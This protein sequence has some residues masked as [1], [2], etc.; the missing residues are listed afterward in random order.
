MS[1]PVLIIGA[2]VAGMTAAV[3]LADSG[4][5]TILVERKYTVG[6]N[7]LDLYK[8]FPTD[9]CFYCFEGNRSRPGIR[10]CFYR[11]ALTDQPNIELKIGSQIEE[12]SGEPGKFSVNI[13]IG[14]QYVSPKKCIMCGLCLEYSEA[15]TLISPQCQPQAMT[16]DPSKMDDGAKKSQ[17]ECPTKAIDLDAKATTETVLVSDIVIATGYHE[18]QPVNV[19]E[20][21][22]GKHPNIITQLELAKILDPNGKTEGKVVRPSDGSPAKRIMMVQCVGSRDEN[23]YPY[24]SKICCVFALKHANILALERE[25]VNCSVVYMDIRTY[26]RH[27]RYYREAREA[28]VEFIRGRITRVDPK[29]D[30]LEVIVYDSLLDKYLKF[31]V[32]LFVLS[33]A[34]E[35]PEGGN[36][37]IE[38]LGLQS[39]SGF[40][41]AA[42]PVSGNEVVAGDHIYACGAALGPSEVPESVTQ[43]RAVVS[44]ILQS[45]K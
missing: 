34:L 15:F 29:G 13:N 38:S 7:S 3:E 45:R 16:F 19:D 30:S 23:Y 4:V 31:P 40:V 17:E 42:D 21:G 10:K 20:Y 8:A 5:K 18:M 41:G 35:P 44:K 26:D 25:D 12:I 33:S 9:D 2:G 14:P 27:E 43:A 24:C 39:A 36:K 11:S 22:Y 28:G 32:D 6:G 1:H 37:I